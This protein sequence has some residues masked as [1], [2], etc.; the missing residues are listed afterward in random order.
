MEFEKRHSQDSTCAV[1]LVWLVLIEWFQIETVLRTSYQNPIKVAFGQLVN[2][3]NADA[4]AR[5]IEEV[6]ESFWPDGVWYKPIPARS[7]EEKEATRLKAREIFIAQAPDGLKIA[8]GAGGTLSV[9]FGAGYQAYKFDHTATA[10]AFGRIHDSLQQDGMTA[11]VYTVLV[12]FLR[13]LLL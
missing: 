7:E 13:L 12:D 9:S 6:Q 1:H 3:A 5:K 8:L 11:L 4:I 10:E 2:T